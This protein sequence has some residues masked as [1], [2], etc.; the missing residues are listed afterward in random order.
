MFRIGI[1]EFKNGH[2]KA[3]TEFL[4]KGGKNPHFLRNFGVFYQFLVNSSGF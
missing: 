2:L 1:G 3:E 4:L